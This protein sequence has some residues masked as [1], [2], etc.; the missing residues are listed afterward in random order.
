M[1]LLYPVCNVTVRKQCEILSSH[2]ILGDCSI[3]LS[4]FTAAWGKKSFG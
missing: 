1:L 2:F 3:D 4:I